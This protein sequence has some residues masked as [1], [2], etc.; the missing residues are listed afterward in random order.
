MTDE[1]N[2]FLLAEITLDSLESLNQD[3][4]EGSELFDGFELLDREHA[5]KIFG[6]GRDDH[7]NFYSL[8]AWMVLSIYLS[9]F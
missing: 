9:L 6:A 7:E 8:A 3:G 2:A 5:P 4:A 1:S